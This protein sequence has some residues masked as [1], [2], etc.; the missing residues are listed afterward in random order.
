MNKEELTLK[1]TPQAVDQIIN[2]LNYAIRS[3]GYDTSLVASPLIT[4]IV[5]QVREQKNPAPVPPVP[6]Q[7]AE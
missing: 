1:F 4:D 5:K 6:S 3:G 2:V 7:T